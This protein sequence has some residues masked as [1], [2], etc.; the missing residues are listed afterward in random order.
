[1]EYGMVAKMHSVHPQTNSIFADVQ[2]L[3][4]EKYCSFIHTYV[5]D[6]VRAK[7]LVIIL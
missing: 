2:K 1:M 4:V 3:C 6:Y 7:A 5:D